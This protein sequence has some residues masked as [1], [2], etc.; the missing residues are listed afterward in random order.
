MLRQMEPRSLVSELEACIPALR[1]KRYRRI[2][3]GWEHIVLE[4][5]G[6]Y[7]VRFPT[8]RGGWARLQREMALL[9]WLSPRLSATVPRYELVWPGSRSHPQ[10]FA[11]YR[12]IAGTSLSRNA[13]RA[14]WV[15]QLGEDLGRFLTGLHGLRLPG[16]LSDL[17]PRYTR[18]SWVEAEPKYYRQ[19]RTLV[20]PLL[21][22]ETRRRADLFWTRYLDHFPTVEF[23]PSLIH[24]DLTSGNIIIDRSTGRLSGVIDWGD[25]KVGDPALDFMGS[26]EVSR[27]LGERALAGYGREKSGFRER[28][29]LYLVS[30]AFGE[31]AVGVQTGTEK[32]TQIGLKHIRQ[33]LV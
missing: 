7:I 1:V 26:F 12:K 21:D 20:Y 22:A 23:E 3:K 18:N 25:V 11:G 32:F 27:S 16:E 29:D 17:V 30:S 14:R 19:A 2:T 33:R 28:I 10:R 24:S 4:V 31:V 5:N 9:P 15:D 13:F 6:E 8:L